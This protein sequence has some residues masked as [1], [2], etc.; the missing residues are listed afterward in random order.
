MFMY[1]NMRDAGGGGAA[2]PF[3]SAIWKQTSIDC[4]IGHK[5]EPVLKVLLCLQLRVSST[6]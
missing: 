2:A 5:P 1:S 6:V 4:V 3:E